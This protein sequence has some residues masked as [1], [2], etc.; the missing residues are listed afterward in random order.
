[1]E[2]EKGAGVEVGNQHETAVGGELQAIGAPGL[3][4]EGVDHAFV[5]DIDHRN[6]AVA[7]VRGPEFFAVGCDVEA[8]GA[9]A[10]GNDRLVPGLRAVALEQADGVRSDVRREDHV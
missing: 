9:F 2:N 3:Y 5:G 8:L 7:R 4:S 1:M 6:A 10:D